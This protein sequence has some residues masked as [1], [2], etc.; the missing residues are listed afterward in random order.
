[1]SGPTGFSVA[2][3]A[4]AN[5]SRI[6]GPRGIRRPCASDEQERPGRYFDYD[7]DTGEIIAHPGLTGDARE[8]AWTT[9]TD[10]GLNE[11]DVR[12]YR[13]NWSRQ[14]LDDLRLLPADDRQAFVE[15]WTGQPHE[16]AGSTSM[17][18]AQLRA[19]GEI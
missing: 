15:F 14:F 9:I 3:V 8:K 2:G 12:F 10:L 17:A 19:A 11:I 6:N 16:F 7:P 4:T 18:V 13:I 5:T 1:M